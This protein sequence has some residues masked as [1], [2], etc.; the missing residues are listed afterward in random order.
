MTRLSTG[1]RD[2][3]PAA[4]LENVTFSYGRHAVL[5]QVNLTIARGEFATIVGP[6]GGGKTTLIKLLLG[7]LSPDSGRI[8]FYGWGGEDGSWIFVTNAD[9]SGLRKLTNTAARNAH[10][11][12]SPRN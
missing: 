2:A 12:W 11:V 6:N 10:P 4:R 5:S 9:G 8:A 1:T 7:L 3:A